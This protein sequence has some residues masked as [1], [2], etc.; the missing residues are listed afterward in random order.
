MAVTLKQTSALLVHVVTT[1][2]LWQS[3]V[4]QLLHTEQALSSTTSTPIP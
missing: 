4:R 3:I 1:M 2:L